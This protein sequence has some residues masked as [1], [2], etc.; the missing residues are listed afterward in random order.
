MTVLASHASP[1]TAIQCDEQKP[2]CA[3]CER[4]GRQCPGYR[5]P[6]DMIFRSMNAT[7]ENKSLKPRRR[8]NKANQAKAIVSAGSRSQSS[9]SQS[10]GRC[11]S[12]A[13]LANRRSSASSERPGQPMP[14]DWDQQAICLF[15]EDYV[16]P[17]E[18][19]RGGYLSFLPDLYR[20]H[21]DIAYLSKAL[22][23]VSMASLAN[24]TS[25][26]HLVV[27]ARRSYGEALTLINVA[28]NDE[29]LAKSDELLASLMLLTK[30]EVSLLCD[31][32]GSW[33]DGRQSTLAA[34]RQPYGNRIL[35]V[36][37]SSYGFEGR[38]SSNQ[39]PVLNSTV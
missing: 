25:M 21:Q 13:I 2:S 27:R 23:A 32:S 37:S 35:L 33:A 26:S 4:A 9:D 24:R 29:R 20:Q 14:T 3:R 39:T 17:V 22:H 30:Y 1:N 28:L 6:G 38:I 19:G 8:L 10:S 7:A 34:T 11:Y 5:V 16:I 12:N 31:V 36:R 18:M 15:F